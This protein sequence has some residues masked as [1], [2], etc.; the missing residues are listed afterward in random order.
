[1]HYINLFEKIVLSLQILSD[2]E[3]FKETFKYILYIFLPY[4]CFGIYF[5]KLMLEKNNNKL[6]K[7]EFEKK[8]NLNEFQKY[9]EDDNNHILKYLNLFLK[10]FCF[11]KLISDF[12]CKNEDIVNNLN[13]LSFKNIL[14]LIDMEDFAK[15]FPKNEISI[16]D[17]INKL[18]KT[19]NTNDTFYKLFSS[20]LNSEKVITNII[21]NVKTHKNKIDFEIT[22][23]LILQFIPPKFNFI[24]LDKNIF[25]F[26]E[27]YIGIKCSICQKIQTNSFLCLICGDK[28]CSPKNSNEVDIHTNKCTSG[29]CIYIDMENMKLHLIDNF[30]KNT[31][32]YPIYVNKAGTGPKGSEISNEFNLSYEILKTVIKNYASKDFYFN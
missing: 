5:K 2:Y 13:D 26:I 25:D 18:P 24:N 28:V 19:F 31:K 14:L 7:E 20:V 9:L 22:Q 8:L 23:E 11:I 4:F 29:Y 10:K 30:G 16:K 12:K 15:L 6:N 3:E 27:K 32:L 21:E 17:I 1:M